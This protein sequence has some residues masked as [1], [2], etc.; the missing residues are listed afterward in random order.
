MWINVCFQTC[1]LTTCNFVG[2]KPLAVVPEVIHSVISL[3]C[4]ETTVY[5]H[6]LHLNILCNNTLDFI[7][8]HNYGCNIG[9]F[10]HIV[11]PCTLRKFVEDDSLMM[12]DTVSRNM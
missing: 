7:V 8:F 9:I 10:Y 11:T 5:A 4:L 1:L 3:Y 2:W 12:T 6:V